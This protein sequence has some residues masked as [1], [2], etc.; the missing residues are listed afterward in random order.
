MGRM[1]KRREL[2]AF[3]PPLR[4]LRELA[5]STK[6]RK[7]AQPIQIIQSNQTAQQLQL[8]DGWMNW[9]GMELFSF[10]AL[11]W[12]GQ[13]IHW[14]P[15]NEWKKWVMAAQP[16]KPRQ[17]KRINGME[18]LI[19]EWSECSGM[20]AK[21]EM[22]FDEIKWNELLLR[23]GAEWMKRRTKQPTA[24]RQAKPINQPIALHEGELVVAGAEFAS[25]LFCCL[26]LPFSSLSIAAQARSGQQLIKER[27]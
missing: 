3:G 13:A 18:E 2:T 9:A 25:S 1:K 12:V 23:N 19:C 10:S 17:R 26:S 11:G 8:F 21:K 14:I 16:S 6:Q 7:T 4:R 22:E 20:K 24:A 27:R 5:N 15:F